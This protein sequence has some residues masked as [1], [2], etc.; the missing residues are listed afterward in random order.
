MFKD[1]FFSV[2]GPDC[3]KEILD[4]FNETGS[5]GAHYIYRAKLHL[6]CLSKATFVQIF[7]AVAVCIK[8]KEA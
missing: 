3:I 8:D 6:C 2:C 7:S 1:V 4:R 5:A